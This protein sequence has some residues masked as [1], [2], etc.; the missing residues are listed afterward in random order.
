MTVH[1]SV[2]DAI[3]GTPLFRLARLGAGLAAPVYAKAEFLNIG[4]SVKDRAA[5]SMVLAAER[6]GLLR[7]GGTIIE[8]TS[9][10][11]G[12]GLTIVG[13]RR[14]YR[15]I[16]AV[17]DRAAVEKSDILRA[18]GAEVVLAPT[19]VPAEHPDHLFN[20]VRRL[21][22]EIP[23]AWLANQYDNP[24]NPDAHVRTTGPEVWEQTAGRVTHF[25]A[26][27][28]TGGTISGTGAFLKKVSGGSVTVVGADPESSCYGGGDGSPYF[29]D[30]IGHFLHPGTAEDRWPDSYHREVVDGF[31]RIPDRESLLTARRLAREEGLLAGPSSGTAVA[32]A[33]RVARRLGPEDLVVVLLPDS[34]RSY[35]SKLYSDDW[36][37][38]WG[39]LEEPR[40]AD[41]TEPTVRAVLD[42]AAGGPAR[43]GGWS[44]LSGRPAAVASDAS[45]AEAL[46]V[47]RGVPG[48]VAPVVLARPERPYGI[49]AT[50]VLGSLSSAA[51]ERAVAEGRAAPDGPVAGLLGPALPT[52]GVGQPLSEA[53]EALG[54]GQD[55]ALVLVDGRAVA[56]VHRSELG[57]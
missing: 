30:S 26:G 55:A 29:V 19:T 37:R 6:D 35:L 46:A 11:T 44:E 12:I 43:P 10:N 17:A 5:L 42:A 24:A 8:A 40:S 3:G 20:V 23:G 21:A 32:A 13:R 50:E 39:F 52:V 7:P 16:A 22:E 36:L 18:Y 25:V 28:G 57:A 45:L 56:L 9:G 48:G 27:V 49:S 14:G 34:G 53:R 47:L 54:P 41:D 33:L 4:G 15:V 31:E 1:E 2:V 51:V 38:R